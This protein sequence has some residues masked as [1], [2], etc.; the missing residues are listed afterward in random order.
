[1]RHAETTKNSVKEF[2]D[3]GG[4]KAEASRR[5]NVSRSSVSRWTHASVGGNSESRPLAKD[6]KNKPIALSARGRDS[7]IDPYYRRGTLRAIEQPKGQRKFAIQSLKFD[8]LKNKNF[9]DTVECLINASDALSLAVDT[10][11]DS[12]VDG[13]DLEVDPDDHESVRGR[14]II[15][16]FWENSP[17]DPIA[18]Q[19]RIAYG[20]YVEG[21]TSIELVTYDGKMPINR[22]IE[23]GMPVKIAYVSPFTLT[24]YRVEAKESPIG[25]YDQIVQKTGQGVNDFVVMQDELNPNPYY[26]YNPTS[27]RGT[28]K[29]GSSPIEPAIFSVASM[30]DLISMMVDYTQGQ[31]FPKGIYQIDVSD[32]P[33]EVT[34]DDLKDF[35]KEATEALKAQ[36]DGAD[37]T[38]DIVLSTKLLYT[39]IG[40][41]ES[42]NIDGVDMIM[43]ILER[44]QR[45]SLRLPN[46]VFGGRQRAGGLGMNEKFEW[47]GLSR[48]VRSVRREIEDPLTAF[49][50]LILRLN[51]NMGEVKHKLTDSDIIYQEILAEFLEKKAKAFK[52]TKELGIFNKQELREKFLDPDMNFGTLDTE[53]PDD[54]EDEMMTP[55]MLPT[56]G[57]PNGNEG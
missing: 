49:Y 34:L 46:S 44:I 53:L 35:A 2:V 56:G 14:E 19:K 5:Y 17:E 9:S 25:E 41:I 23:V 4:S 10:Y 12:T 32:L 16:D 3:S 43:E 7:T 15:E 54:L 18:T 28:K 45:R 57:D 26:I 50:T 11:I 33:D 21:G 20:I 36:L 39:L 52:T 51:G 31:V 13:F 8:D 42:A 40:S 1:M 27:I 48:R 22:P 55:P 38:Q 29:L 47:L 6:E 37:I 24:T 30:I